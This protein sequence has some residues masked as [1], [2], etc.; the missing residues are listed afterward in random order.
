[1]CWA[2]VNR[3]WKIN[4]LCCKLAAWERFCANTSGAQKLHQETS[5]PR[6]VFW[7]LQLTDLNLWILYWAYLFQHLWTEVK[8][9]ATIGC[10]FLFQK[11]NRFVPFWQK[12]FLLQ[13]NRYQGPSKSPLW[14][15]LL[16]WQERFWGFQA[17]FPS[18]A[19]IP[20]G[21]EVWLGVQLNPKPQ[22]NHVN[23]W[24]WQVLQVY[25]LLNTGI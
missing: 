1:M 14:T 19:L 8:F 20:V 11:Y 24:T 13:K 9:K 15:T 6:V 17:F 21:P 3:F 25:Y 10:L 4:L 5:G 16:S 2:K 22:S 7:R 18:I 23:L 12:S